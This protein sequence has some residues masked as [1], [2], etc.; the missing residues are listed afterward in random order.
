MSTSME[1]IRTGLLP[2]LTEKGTQNKLPMA[3]IRRLYC[4]DPRQLL[5]HSDL[6]RTHK[7]HRKQVVDSLRALAKLGSEGQRSRRWPGA[8]HVSHKVGQ[9]CHSDCRKFQ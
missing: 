7:S 9:R 2:N 1:T 4:G 8:G 3:S 5:P 6:D